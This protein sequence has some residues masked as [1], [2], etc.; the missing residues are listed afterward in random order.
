MMQPTTADFD[1]TEGDYTAAGKKLLRR[2]NDLDIQPES[3]WNDITTPR[4][5][6]F[7]ERY[8]QYEIDQ[9]DQYPAYRGHDTPATRAMRFAVDAARPW[10][11]FFFDL[12]IAAYPRIPRL[13]PVPPKPDRPEGQ[14]NPTLEELQWELNYGTAPKSAEEELAEKFQ[15][16]RGPEVA[17]N[18]FRRQANLHD[19]AMHLMYLGFRYGDDDT[20]ANGISMMEKTKDFTLRLMSKPHLY[21]STN[22]LDQFIEL[23]RTGIS[24]GGARHTQEIGN[25]AAAAAVSDEFCRLTRLERP[26]YDPDKAPHPL[27]EAVHSMHERTFRYHQ[28]GIYRELCRTLAGRKNM[29]SLWADIEEIRQYSG[30]LNRLHQEAETAY[31]DEGLWSKYRQVRDKG[32]QKERQQW[33]DGQIDLLCRMDAPKSLVG[34]MLWKRAIRNFQRPP[35][36]PQLG[37]SLTWAIQENAFLLPLLRKKETALLFALRNGRPEAGQ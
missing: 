25:A 2:H 6:S 11:K 13:D 10:T 30:D 37:L 32:T 31:E 21:K 34:R 5:G 3:T 12:R 26:P 9:E 1:I 17:L 36:N 35:D 14:E 8:W 33:L 23:R 24:I 18:L 7:Y 27:E 19:V 16:A 15:E 22:V 28:D 20:V 4:P 29:D